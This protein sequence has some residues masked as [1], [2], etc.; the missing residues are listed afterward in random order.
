MKKVLI[1]LSAWL[2]IIAINSCTEISDESTLSEKEYNV[3]FEALKSIRIDADLS[4]EIHN[5]VSASANKG[6]DENLYLCE[7]WMDEP[8][9]KV[10]SSVESSILKT[11]LEQ[12]FKNK[13]TKSESVIEYLKNS[14]WVIYWPYSEYWDGKTLPTI[15]CAP[16]NIEQEWNYGY[17]I[18]YNDNGEQVAERVYVDDDYAF[19][20]PV[21]IIKEES[22]QQY[23]SLPNFNKGEF[24]KGSTYYSSPNTKTI[25]QVHV[26]RMVRA[27]VTK[28]YDSI[29]QGGSEFKIVAS[30]PYP[31]FNQSE[32]EPTFTRGEIRRSEFKTLNYT[33]NT[34]WDPKEISNGLLIVEVDSDIEFT[35]YVS[36]EYDDDTC[37][38]YLGP[39]TLCIPITIEQD[40]D[41]VLNQVYKRTYVYS[42]AGYQLQIADSGGFN[43]NMAINDILQ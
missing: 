4:T 16:T 29:F 6:I 30:Y 8:K 1:L 36:L 34:D 7:L 24:S 19:E 17:K 26:W 18:Y 35:I 15:T 3:L 5:S 43:F 20:H 41:M 27:Q 37:I 33:L 31:S 25:N 22:E 12:Y 21:W 2:S 10:S 38:P 11:R 9:V 39:T 32:F 14:D 42:T 13:A 23:S 28:Q 40:D